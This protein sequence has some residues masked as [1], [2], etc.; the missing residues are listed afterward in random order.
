MTG[1]YSR[2][3]RRPNDTFVLSANFSTRL[4]PVRTI[5]GKIIFLVK[6]QSLPPIPLKQCFCV[7]LLASLWHLLKTIHH[8]RRNG[9][10]LKMIIENVRIHIGKTSHRAKA[11]VEFP[12]Y[13]HSYTNK[14]VRY[15][16]SI[17]ALRDKDDY[18]KRN[19]HH[20]QSEYRV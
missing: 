14:F 15:I 4:W 8:L 6:A 19:H 1:I 9:T 11:L 3:Y 10:L 12:I 5:R 16:P 13:Q 17:M 18:H 20:L 7:R 2:W